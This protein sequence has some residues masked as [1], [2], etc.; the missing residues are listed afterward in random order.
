M[1]PKDESRIFDEHRVGIEGEIRQTNDFVAGAC[2]CP[3][4][5][6]VLRCGLGSV[7]RVPLEVRQ[8]ALGE[9]GTDCAGEGARHQRCSFCTISPPFMTKRACSTAE[10]SRVGSPSTATRS[11]RRPC[12]IDPRSKR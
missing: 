3:L 8:L 4:V 6:M 5:G 1:L 7:D 12:L 10:T 2:K 9:A 11:A